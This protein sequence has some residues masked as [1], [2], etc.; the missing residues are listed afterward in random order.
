M[1][2][3][4]LQISVALVG[5][6]GLVLAVYAQLGGFKPV[7]VYLVRS[8]GPQRLAGA[9]FEGNARDSRLDSLFQAVR[10]LHQR[11]QLRGTLGSIYYEVSPERR[12]KGEVSAFVGVWLADSAAS[13]PRGYRLR[14]VGASRLVQ[15]RIES[16]F[17]VSPLP[18]KVQ[19][20]MREYARQRKLQTENFV[21]EK[22]LNDESITLETPVK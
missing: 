5:L 22:Y 14:T 12:R 4:L 2:K 16:H 8:P 3:R 15:A 21:M 1:N 7:A 10:Q 11:G 19:V 18:E 17:L 20:A 9:S 6:A 13:L